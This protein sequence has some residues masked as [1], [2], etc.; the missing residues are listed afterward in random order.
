MPKFIVS[1]ENDDD[2]DH[3]EAEPQSVEAILSNHYD[4]VT[5]DDL[6]DSSALVAAAREQRLI[7]TVHK[8]AGWNG[9]DISVLIEEG[10]L[11]DGD[12]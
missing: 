3:F 8:L 2:N 12:V 11:Q 1:I 10:L 4:D 6:D 9:T 5:V 7:N